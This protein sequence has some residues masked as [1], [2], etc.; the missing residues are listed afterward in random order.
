VC[1]K[2]YIAYSAP[3]ARLCT[4]RTRMARSRVD[5]AEHIIYFG[6]AGVAGTHPALREFSP[7]MAR[8]QKGR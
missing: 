5:G 4:Y 6:V 8:E 2:F 7:Q 3:S 1:A